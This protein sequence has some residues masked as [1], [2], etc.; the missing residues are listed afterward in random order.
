MPNLTVVELL[1]L[2]AVPLI[3][4]YALVRFVKWAWKRD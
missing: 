4:L 3:I 2:I 1:L